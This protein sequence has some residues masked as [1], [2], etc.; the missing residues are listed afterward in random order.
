[1]LPADAEASEPIGGE[2][3][4]LG[5]PSLGMEIPGSREHR[6]TGGLTLAT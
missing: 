2:C 1:M 4:A 5:L 3:Q 6:K